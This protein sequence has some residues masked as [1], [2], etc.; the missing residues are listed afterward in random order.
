MGHH[1]RR[2]SEHRDA[3]N[4][5]IAVNGV[6]GFA[7]IDVISVRREKD[8]RDGVRG[9]DNLRVAAG[10]D[11]AQPQAVLALVIHHREQVFAVGGYGGDDCL[12]GISDLRDAEILERGRRRTMQH[13]VHAKPSR[14]QDNQSDDRSSGHAKFVLFRSRDNCGAAAV[15]RLC[16]TTTRNRRHAACLGSVC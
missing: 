1:L 12:G 13:R 8:I 9:R 11:I 3:I 14:S 15:R 6:L 2:A 16:H 5:E 7:E 4:I 10:R